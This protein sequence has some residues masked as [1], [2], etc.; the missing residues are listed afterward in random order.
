MG[1]RS[2]FVPWGDVA[3]EASFVGQQKCLWLYQHGL[4]QMIY[5][6]TRK[7]AARQNTTKRGLNALP[8]V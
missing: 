5:H 7:R 3:G 6:G 2:G 1:P 4:G 8:T